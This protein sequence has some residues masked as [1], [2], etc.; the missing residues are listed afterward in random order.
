[1]RRASAIAALIACLVYAT[2]LPWHGAMRAA[3]LSSAEASL[4][5][6]MQSSLCLGGMPADARIATAPGSASDPANDEL[7]PAGVDCPVCKS[8]A[9]MGMV[10]L[11]AAEL[12][13]LDR[14]VGQQVW[15]LPDWSASDLASIDPRSRGP[16]A[17]A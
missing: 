7:P 1:M 5:V 8:L 2:V 14:P 3:W 9:A 4:A 15:H 13:L 6:A 10:V 12:G 17:S 16:P 11:A